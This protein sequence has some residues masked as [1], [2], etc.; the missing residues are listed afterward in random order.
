MASIDECVVQIP[1]PE[2]L[3]VGESLFYI[4]NTLVPKQDGSRLIGPL[5]AEGVQQKREI[6]ELLMS[7]MNEDPEKYPFIVYKLERVASR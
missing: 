5:N 2:N 1:L 3:S 4:E 7:R 6:Y